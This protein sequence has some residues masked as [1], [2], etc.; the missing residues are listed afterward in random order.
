MLTEEQIKK[1]KPFI[2]KRRRVRYVVDLLAFCNKE[3][4]NYQQVCEEVNRL[5]S[6]NIEISIRC[7]L[8]ELENI[9]ARAAEAG[10]IRTADFIRSMALRA[11]VRSV[12]R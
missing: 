12:N 9:K 3:E 4:P 10:F 5:I 2:G 8:A 7:T 6:R 11:D 1:L